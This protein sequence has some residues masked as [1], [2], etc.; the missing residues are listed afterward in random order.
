MNENKKSIP[1]VLVTGATGYVG[2]RLI[3]ALAGSNVQVRCLARKPEYLIPKVPGTMEVVQGDVMDRASLDRALAGCDAAYYL[4]HSMGNEPKFEEVDRQAAQNFSEAVK[5]AGVKKLIYLGGLANAKAVGLSDHLASRMEVGKILRESGVPTLEFQASIIIGSGSFSFEMLRSLVD[6]LPVMITPRWVETHC[7]P[8]AIGDVVAYLT[9]ALWKDVT[10]SRVYQIGGARSVSY[11]ELMREYARQRGLRRWMIPVPFLTPR[12]SSLWLTLV[13]PVYAKVG[14]RLIEGLRNETVVEDPGAQNDFSVAP[15]GLAEAIASALR[16]ED[17]EFA[18]TRWS[19]AFSS[20]P[21]PM[22]FGGTYGSRL[23]DSR[24]LTTSAPPE[25]V[26][27]VIESIGGKN[28]WYFGDLLWKVR[29]WMDMLVGGVGLRRGRRDADHLWP[30]DAVDFFRVE[31]LER[32]RLLR[33]R[34]EM[35]LPGRAW[36]QFEV[37]GDGMGSRIRSTA[38]FDPLGLVGQIYWWVLYPIHRVMFQGMLRA[39]ARK[40]NH[41]KGE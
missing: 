5:A 4:V 40:S 15:L 34:A 30:G 13:T 39:I 14:A 29:G 18:L 22:D 37:D 2:G 23:V 1:R 35:R 31:A 27:E 9:E 24:V 20:G 25:K 7:Q 26:F 32:P 33:L 41:K 6:R 36:L 19:D 10:E 16:N 21:R 3:Q 8:I 11:G 17:Q 38:L 28:G 12:L